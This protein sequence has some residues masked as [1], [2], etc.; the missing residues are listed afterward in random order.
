M[1]IFYLFFSV[2]ILLYA[3]GAKLNCTINTIALLQPKLLEK[4]LDLFFSL[5][6]VCMST[7]YL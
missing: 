6:S 3:G 1:Q 7:D 4:N 2:N 5:C